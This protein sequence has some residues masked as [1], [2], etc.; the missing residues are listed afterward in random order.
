[1]FLVSN[2]QGRSDQEDEKWLHDVHQHTIAHLSAERIEKIQ[3]HIMESFDDIAA[4]NDEPEDASDDDQY[5]ASSQRIDTSIESTDDQ[6]ST[7]HHPISS[8]QSHDNHASKNIHNQS[9]VDSETSHSIS[10][11][12]LE[13]ASESTL[14]QEM[15]QQKMYTTKGRKKILKEIKRENLKFSLRDM[16]KLTTAT[17]EPK[18]VARLQKC[19]VNAQRSTQNERTLKLSARNQ[20]TKDASALTNLSADDS[21]DEQS[22]HINASIGAQR[23]KRIKPVDKT[24]DALSADTIQTNDIAS[25]VSHKALAQTASSFEALSVSASMSAIPSVALF[26]FICCYRI[27]VVTAVIVGNIYPPSIQHDNNHRHSL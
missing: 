7:P 11:D 4:M 13:L 10:L 5:E 1:M 2:R 3:Q 12:C 16:R 6:I 20:V 8:I 22:K 15:N 26:Q 23:R 25:E 9:G 14:K 17:D 21:A 18:N 19:F 24:M 27:S